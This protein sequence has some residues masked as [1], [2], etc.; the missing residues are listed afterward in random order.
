MAP[1]R[2]RIRAIGTPSPRA[3]DLPVGEGALEWVALPLP[4][5]PDPVGAAELCG[6]VEVAAAL[7][8]ALEGAGVPEGAP[9]LPPPATRRVKKACYYYERQDTGKYSL[10]AHCCCCS[11]WAAC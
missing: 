4:D 7:L 6:A 10:A 1:P 8:A 9:L 3:L 11:P 2:P 5:P